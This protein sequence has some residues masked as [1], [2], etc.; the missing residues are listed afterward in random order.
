MSDA[1]YVK[2][3]R[4]FARLHDM[5]REAVALRARL[6]QLRYAGED[7]AEQERIERRLAHLEK[8]CSAILNGAPSSESSESRKRNIEL[9]EAVRE[10]MQEQHD[11]GD[12]L[13]RMQAL[14]DLKASGELRRLGFHSRDVLQR[15][16][17]LTDPKPVSELGL[18]ALPK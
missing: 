14:R 10:K 16:R 11:R 7:L 8:E 12:K 17:K 2:A 6:Q 4:D 13:N 1:E 5:K 18:P 9:I 15:C 3:F